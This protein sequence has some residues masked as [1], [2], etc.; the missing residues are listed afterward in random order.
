M[1]TD[2]DCRICQLRP[3][4]DAFEA[5]LKQATNITALYLSEQSAMSDFALEPVQLAA[6]ATLLGCDVRR[7]DYVVDV[8]A[9]LRPS[10]PE[11]RP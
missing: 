2:C 4:C 11:E 9:R 6:L 5:A 3:E 1:S 8:L 7:E 10:D